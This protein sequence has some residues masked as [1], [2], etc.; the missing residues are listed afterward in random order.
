MKG[1]AQHVTFVPGFFHL[2]CFQGSSKLQPVSAP[3]SL[4]WLES[5]AVQI[6]QLSSVHAL[7]ERHLDCFQSISSH[8]DFSF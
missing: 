7:V 6:L 4:T 8:F 5:T 1:I 3:H 2:E